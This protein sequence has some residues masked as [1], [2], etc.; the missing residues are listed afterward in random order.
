MS[1]ISPEV[2]KAVAASLSTTETAQPEVVA[3]GNFVTEGAEVAAE[4]AEAPKVE[5]PKVEDT[6][7]AK[8]Q[9]ALASKFAALSKKE[10]QLRE[11]EKTLAAK[12]EQERA[13]LVAESE[14]KLKNMVSLEDLRND[15]LGAID[16]AGLTFEQFAQIVLNDGKPT[17]EMLLSQTEQKMLKKLEELENKLKAKDEESQKSKEQAARE[18]LLGDIRKQIDTNDKYEFIRAE[19]AYDTIIETMEEY[20]NQT[21]ESDGEGKILSIDEAAD[22]VEAYLEQE[23]EKFLKLNKVQSKFQGKQEPVKTK[24]APTLS[25]AVTSPAPKTST[26]FMSDD[27]SKAEAARLLKWVE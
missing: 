12:F 13:K 21:L 10:K 2:A 19:G 26:R 11:R 27:E 20:Y 8:E 7:A 17:Q 1:E 25:N 3:E 4:G 9:A 6:E 18:S 5:E 14:G 23:A 24:T 15:P 16:K 22:A